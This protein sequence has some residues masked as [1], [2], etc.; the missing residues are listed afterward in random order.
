MRSPWA[1]GRAVWGVVAAGLLCALWIAFNTTGL[2]Y[3]LDSYRIV[4]GL[5][6][7]APLHVY[8]AVNQVSGPTT[9][10]RWPYPPGYFPWIIAAEA[11]SRVSH[12]SFDGWIK[13]PSILAGA[14]IAII[15]QDSLKRLGR[16]ARERLLAV[17]LVS[18]GPVF[19]AVSA[20]HGQLDAIAILPAVAAIWSWDRIRP[21]RRALAA[22]LLIGVGILLKSVPLLMLFALLPTARN[23]REIA[24][25]VLTA[26]AVP[27]VAMLPFLIADP[28]GALTIGSY[29]GIPGLG[30]VSMLL[31]P[32]LVRYWTVGT[33]PAPS[34]AEFFLLRHGTLLSVAGLAAAAVWAQ[35]RHLEPRHA[36]VFLWL[37]FFSLASGFGF[38]YLVWG[39][40]FFLMAGYTL[41]VL[42]LELW[43]VMP[44]ALIYGHLRFPHNTAVYVAMMGLL[45]VSWLTAA[46]AAG[47]LFPHT[48]QVQQ[49]NR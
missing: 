32:S 26:A 39:I 27:L 30:G 49:A 23:R 2:Q 7:H 33:G 36:A 22:G 13:V 9:S 17:A 3:D 28:H 20:Y 6:E 1:A 29:P 16:S 12:W 5:L 10:Y 38:Q 19:L 15:V 4:A 46:A 37:V 43:V 44:M 40:P 42:V 14:G 35:F 24:T 48:R 45:W 31:Q 18:F 21:P 34:A 25:L 41:P 11:L 8:S 47:Y